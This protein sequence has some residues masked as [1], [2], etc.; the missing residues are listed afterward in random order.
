MFELFYKRSLQLRKGAADI[1]IHLYII[2]RF[3]IFINFQFDV[4]LFFPLPI[5]PVHN[6]RN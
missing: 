6:T 4:H 2:S 5:I 1:G 3:R